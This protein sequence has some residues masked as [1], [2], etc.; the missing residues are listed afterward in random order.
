MLT[1]GRRTSFDKP[2]QQTTTLSLFLSAAVGL[3][4]AADARAQSPPTI[5]GPKARDLGRPEAVQQGLNLTD[6]QR[7]WIF[8][9]INHSGV[10]APKGFEPTIGA[11]VPA[12]LELHPLP[13]RIT[14][15]MPALEAYRYA[16]V[17]LRIILVDEDGRLVEIIDNPLL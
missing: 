13:P 10:L 1:N 2:R 14:R 7:R 15:D 6:A 8:V 11:K 4:F 17:N 5:I 16:R 3:A 12:N 9:G